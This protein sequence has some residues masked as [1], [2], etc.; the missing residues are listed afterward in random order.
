VLLWVAD[1]CHRRHSSDGS[2]LE[3][4]LGQIDMWCAANVRA[5][6]RQLIF[7]GDYIDRGPDSHQVLQIVQHLQAEGAICLRGNHEELMLQATESEG[8]LTNFLANGGDATITSLRTPAAFRRAQEWMR[9]LRTS[10][11]DEVRYYVHAGI[12]PGVPLDQQTAETKLWI[13]DSFI[14]HRGPFPK[15]IVHGHTPTIYL[16]PQQTRPDVR[17]N[18]CNVD[19]GAGMNGPL[20]AAIFNDRQT[21]PIHTISVGA[22]RIPCRHAIDPTT[23]ICKFLA[24]SNEF[25]SYPLEREASWCCRSGSGRSGMAANAKTT[26]CALAI[27]SG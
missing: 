1:H 25:A 6:L 4:L 10:H 27:S 21:K 3:N 8:D 2:K 12:H 13:R 14:C 16:D 15:Y 20:S 22:S 18:R 24:P 23:T 7:F 19:T 5:A 9:A 17:D 26:S 11:E